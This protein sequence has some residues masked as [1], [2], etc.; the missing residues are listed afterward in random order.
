MV[1]GVS[2]KS[3]VPTLRQGV[4][5]SFDFWGG[6]LRLSADFNRFDLY[7]Q[8]DAMTLVRDWPATVNPNDGWEF[9]TFVALDTVNIVSTINQAACLSLVDTSE[10]SG[11][12][13]SNIQLCIYNLGAQAFQV[14]L[15]STILGFG[16]TVLNTAPFVTTYSKG[17]AAY[18]RLEYIAA[19]YPV[20]FRAYWKLNQNE[21]W[22]LFGLWP[23]QLNMRNGPINPTKWVPAL[24]VFN[25]DTQIRAVGLFSYFRIGPAACSAK[26]TERYVSGASASA[27]IYGL[28]QG[29]T[30]TFTVTAK[31][32]AGWGAPSAVTAPVTIP[33]LASTTGLQLLTQGRPCSMNIYYDEPRNCKVA[34][35]G[36]LSTYVYGAYSLADG[37]GGFGWLTIDLGASLSVRA[38]KFWAISTYADA[39]QVWVSSSPNFILDGQRCDPAVYPPLVSAIPGLVASFPCYLIGSG[40][41]KY[42]TGRYVTY[43]IDPSAAGKIVYLYEF[44]A[45]GIA[46]SPLVSQN[47]ACDMSSTKGIN[48]CA[49]ALDGRM[50]TSAQNNDD[51]TPANPA[52]LRV[53]LGSQVAIDSIKIFARTDSMAAARTLDNMQVWI[54]DLTKWNF[55][56]YDYNMLCNTSYVP[57]SV[58]ALPGN[59]ST[60]QCI[61]NDNLGYKTGMPAMGRYLHVVIPTG[62]P[63][64]SITELQVFSNGWIMVSQSKPCSMSSSLG[65]RLCGV[66]FDG[67]VNYYN[68]YAA[69]TVD[70]DNFLTVDLGLSS[71]VRAIKIYEFPNPGY[72]VNFEM[73]VGDNPSY[74]LNTRCDPTYIPRAF[75]FLAPMYQTAAFGCALTGRYVTVHAPNTYVIAQEVQV[76]VAN[77]C[78][79]RGAS[80]AT[81]L[82]G[83]TCQNAGWG[84]VCI[85]V[86]NP[87]WV[88]VYGSTSSTCS[89][90]TWDAQELVCQPPCPDV[91]APLYSSSCS[92]VFYSQSFNIDGALLQFQSLDPNRQ[93]VGYPTSAPPQNARW[94][95]IDGTLLASNEDTCLPDLHLAISSSKIQQWASGFTITASVMTSTR[96]G[97]FFRAQDYANL[98][99]FWYDTTTGDAVVER[100]VKG[101]T[102]ELSRVNSYRGFEHCRTNKAATELVS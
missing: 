52:W 20:A 39:S 27:L 65:G 26:A 42:P 88:P 8:L 17:S 44:Q 83:S 40:Q 102:F 63:S 12:G 36:S 98:V 55:D 57:A 56:V 94:Y 41:T 33:V 47:M 82:A 97:L 9:E 53:D 71:A 54:G 72:M 28:T 43:R 84:Q 25:K 10:F 73:Y 58:A 66:A 101:A 75:G 92:Q 35:D 77:L 50:D 81:Q 90:A 45:F 18:F 51:A 69:S 37:Q 49:F 59:T 48:T 74:H 3:A 32:N 96:A 67:N 60:F 64:L 87:G 68:G 24:Q 46:P 78:P 38:I 79:A 1:A 80:G 11:Y 30:Y 34:I 86:C 89:G 93:A 15:I 85:Y 2:P 6:Y 4:T 91:L 7:D 19:E 70:P 16:T 5:N 100:V 23:S 22:N 62:T 14:Q 95:Q 21:V 31:T 29:S 76:F 99:R 61:V 13:A